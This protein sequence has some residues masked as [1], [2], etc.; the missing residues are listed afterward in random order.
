MAPRRSLF[1]SGSAARGSPSRRLSPHYALR[2]NSKVAKLD[3]LALKPPLA[4]HPLQWVEAK[5][6][7]VVTL[8]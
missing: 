7:V 4:A 8:H 2:C 3:K 6:M 5:T 1:T